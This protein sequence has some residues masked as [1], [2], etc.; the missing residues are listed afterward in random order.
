M[1]ERLRRRFSG[2]PKITVVSDGPSGLEP[3][4]LDVAVINSVVQYLS[5][6]DLSAA[7][8]QIHRLLAPGGKLVVADVIPHEVGPIED[9]SALLKYAAKE[10]FLI[11]TILGLARTAFSNYGSVRAAHGIAKYSQSEF[12]ELLA[13]HGY[14]AERIAE[15]FGHNQRRMTFVA[16][17][18][19]P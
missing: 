7:L 4:S 6:D 5:P 11:A 3:S 15:N 19:G 14:A 16:R 18:A 1:R 10:G 2:H 8:V 12:L 17:A 13:R 9:A